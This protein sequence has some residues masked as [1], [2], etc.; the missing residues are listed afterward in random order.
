MARKEDK[1]VMSDAARTLSFGLTMGQPTKPPSRII[2]PAGTPRTQG[3]A[4]DIGEAITRAQ[5]D[6]YRDASE[7]KAAGRESPRLVF[8]FWACLVII[9]GMSAYFLVKA[10]LAP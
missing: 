4:L 5:M 8:A 10:L 9:G 6:E 2:T 3:K 7:A 1:P